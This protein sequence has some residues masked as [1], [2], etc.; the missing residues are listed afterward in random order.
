MY[1][2]VHEVRWHVH[3]NSYVLAWVAEVDADAGQRIRSA[4]GAWFQP[5]QLLPVQG[6]L[7]NRRRAAA[8]ECSRKKPN[9]RNGA[10]PQIANGVDV[11]P[12]S[13]P[14]RAALSLQL[15]RLAQQRRRIW[16]SA[17]PVVAV[18][19]LSTETPWR[20]GSRPWR[21]G[22]TSGFSTFEQVANPKGRPALL[23]AE[24]LPC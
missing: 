19:W 7:R 1:L 22:C 15:V 24:Q 10:D 20:C 17:A 6:A 14:E 13:R 21:C 16:P 9:V 12:E 18:A 4:Q 11:S 3:G 8:A 5:G 2:G 23:R